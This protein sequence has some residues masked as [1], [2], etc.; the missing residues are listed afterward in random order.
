VSS[1][2]VRQHQNL[3]EWVFELFV[4]LT[5]TGLLWNTLQEIGFTAGSL[6]YDHEY[7]LV[8]ITKGGYTINFSC[9]IYDGSVKS[10]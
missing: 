8:F 7:E 6:F 5:S 3:C 10:V 2:G 4:N 9:E 1:F